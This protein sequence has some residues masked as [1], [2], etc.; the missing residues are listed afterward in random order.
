MDVRA[1]IKA[2]ANQVSDTLTLEDGKV[3]KVTRNDD[4]FFYRVNATTRH[5]PAG[6]CVTQVTIV[7]TIKD[8]QLINRIRSG[9]Y[10]CDIGNWRGEV[11][12]TK[13]AGGEPYELVITVV[14]DVAAHAFSAR[15]TILSN[16]EGA[17]RL[18]TTEIGEHDDLAI[19]PRVRRLKE[20]L[21]KLALKRCQGEVHDAATH[22]EIPYQ[23]LLDLMQHHHI[24]VPQLGTNASVPV[25]PLTEARFRSD[26]IQVRAALEQ[27]NGNKAQ[28]ARLLDID[29]QYMFRMIEMHVPG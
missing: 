15:D 24:G 16:T 5:I 29:A 18:S 13:Y 27:T 17:R 25:L 10:M 3:I 8:K 26:G 23:D 20:E 6:L 14:A 4:R 1:F 2:S 7:E 28:A 21:I 22:L 9:L 12:V 11:K 19:A